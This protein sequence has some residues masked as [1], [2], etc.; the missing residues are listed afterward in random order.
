MGNGDAGRIISANERVYGR[1]PSRLEVGTANLP[2]LLLDIVCTIGNSLCSAHDLKSHRHTT[3]NTQHSVGEKSL[4]I[5]GGKKRPRHRFTIQTGPGPR[6]PQSRVQCRR[7]SVYSK[8]LTKRHN[9]QCRRITPSLQ[10]TPNIQTIW[11]RIRR[12]RRTYL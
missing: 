7:L 8:N 1:L 4:D 6:I 2:R 3:H 9:L 5:S 12:C 11:I 10:R